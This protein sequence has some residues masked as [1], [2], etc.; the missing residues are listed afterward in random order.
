MD[1][2]WHTLLDSAPHKFWDRYLKDRNWV[3]IT[4]D[5]VNRHEDVGWAHILLGYRR[6]SMNEA[7]IIQW[8]QEVDITKRLD[9]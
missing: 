1:L 2:T 7:V 8:N 3:F 5:A 6:K 9:E 4:V